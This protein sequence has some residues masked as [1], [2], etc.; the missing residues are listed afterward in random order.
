MILEEMIKS[1]V[2]DIFHDILVVFWVFG[3][4]PRGIKRFA[5]LE[6]ILLALICYQWIAVLGLYKSELFYK[7]FTWKNVSE[8]KCKTYLDTEKKLNVQICTYL[9]V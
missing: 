9:D 3:H 2:F 5:Y 1:I 7:H 8:K 4:T 6:K